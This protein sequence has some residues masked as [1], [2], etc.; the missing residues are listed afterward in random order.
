MNHD[1]HD[2]SSYS[3]GGTVMATGRCELLGDSY[4]GHIRETMK[5]GVLGHLVGR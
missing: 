4:D 1:A 2:L 5:V 3:W